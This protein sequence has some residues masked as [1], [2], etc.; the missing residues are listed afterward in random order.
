MVD[1]LDTLG[2]EDA[3]ESRFTSGHLPVLHSSI[4]VEDA[5]S[6]QLKLLALG[7]ASAFNDLHPFKRSSN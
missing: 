6:D 3:E 5:H 7:P 1:H 4:T 2:D